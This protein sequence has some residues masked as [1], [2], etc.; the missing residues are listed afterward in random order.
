MGAVNHQP[1]IAG[2]GINLPSVTLKIKTISYDDHN[3]AKT[4]TGLGFAWIFYF[5]RR[6]GLENVESTGR[7][8]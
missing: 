6:I 5:D 7:A 3:R 4:R 1:G 2:C 8:P